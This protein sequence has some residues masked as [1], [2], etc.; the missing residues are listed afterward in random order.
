MESLDERLHVTSAAPVRPSR[1]RLAGNNGALKF[2]PVFRDHTSGYCI[3]CLHRSTCYGRMHD[4]LVEPW[5]GD[6][7]PCLVQMDARLTS[8][9]CDFRLKLAPFGE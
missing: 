9:V 8:F 1:P 3:P 7:A 2:A 5:V 6:Q 4:A